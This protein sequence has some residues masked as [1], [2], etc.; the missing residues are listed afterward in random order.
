MGEVAKENGKESQR[1]TGAR[2]KFRCRVCGAKLTIEGNTR[3]VV[4]DR[5]KTI[6]GR[7]YPH[8]STLDCPLF[9]GKTPEQ[10]KA[11]PM[12]EVLEE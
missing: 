1:I 8:P 2:M 12:I 10:L 4:M 3:D 11:D 9:Q 5:A 6:Y 7:A